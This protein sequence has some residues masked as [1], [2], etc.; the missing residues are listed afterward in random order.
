MRPAIALVTF[1]TVVLA[2]AACSLPLAPAREA[3][4]SSS[5]RAIVGPELPPLH[6]PAAVEPPTPTASRTEERQ[7]RATPARTSLPLLTPTGPARARTP[8]GLPAVSQPDRPADLPR[9]R[10]ARVVDGDTLDVVLDGAT[11]R[12]RLIGVDTPETVDPRSPVQCYGREAAARTRALAED[13]TVWLENDHSQGDKDIYGR[14][15]R[16]V[17]L[18]DGT[19]LNFALILDGYGVELLYG[20]PY[21][22]R[23]PFMHAQESA[24]QAQRGLWSPLAC[25]GGASVESTPLPATPGAGATSAPTSSPA[26]AETATPVPTRARELATP[27]STSVATPGPA[28]EI[29]SV[30]S[31][32]RAGETAQVVARTI[33]SAPCSLKVL[34]RSALR[35]EEGLGLR[36]AEPD[37]RVAW[38][39]T[40]PRD[41][42]VGV[43]TVTVTCAGISRMAALTVV[44]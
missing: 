13:Q 26:L 18:S 38:R 7:P 1:V 15:L 34:Y 39:W 17:W 23:T 5:P 22:Y 41:A 24:R 29:L 42:P 4:P 10:V 30:T 43:G 40:V 14:L 6:T 12:V 8:T 28:L 19:L 20:A 2:L 21:K 37:G 35:T 31:P 33:P 11:V 44:E 27:A 9:A 32:V 16:Y 3:T 25:A 36:T